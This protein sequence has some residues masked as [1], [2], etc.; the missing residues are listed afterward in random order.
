MSPESIPPKTYILWEI[1]IQVNNSYWCY[2][3]SVHKAGPVY[4]RLVNSCTGLKRIYRAMD[5]SLP[6]F[7][8]LPRHTL[9]PTPRC[10]IAR[11]PSWHLYWTKMKTCYGVCIHILCK[12]VYWY[13]LLDIFFFF[14]CLR[15]QCGSGRVSDSFVV[16]LHF[17]T[18]SLG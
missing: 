16:L 9:V 1:C 13:S 3:V 10:N 11:S 15:V 17:L 8:T 14:E 7:L 6:L 5:N 4:S 12:T 18:Y 2:E